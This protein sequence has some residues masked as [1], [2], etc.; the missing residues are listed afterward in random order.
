[1]GDMGCTDNCRLANSTASAKTIIDGGTGV[2]MTETDDNSAV[3]ESWAVNGTSQIVTVDEVAADKSVVF[4]Y[5]GD[6]AD[7][8]ITYNDASIS[9]DAGSGDWIAG[10]TAYVTV[11][12]PDMNKQ[13]G[14]AETLEIG[15]EDA[16]I[17]TIKVGSP[18]T[19]KEADGNSNL[20]SGDANNNAGVQVGTSTL[21]YYTLAVYNT[22]DNS[23]RL[24]IIHSADADSDACGNATCI[25]G[26]RAATAATTSASSTHTWINVTTAH[27]RAELVDLAG[28]AVLNYDVSGPAGDLSSTAVAVYVVDSGE[29]STNNAGGLIDAL[30]AGNARAGVV[31]LDDDTQWIK[32]SDVASVQSFTTTGATEAGTVNVGV[33]FKIT[34]PVGSFLNTTHDYAIA[35]DFCNFDQDNGSNT[36][37]CIYRIEAE[38][39]GD[40]TGVFEGT[41]DYVMLNNSTDISGETESAHAGNDEEVEDLMTTNSDGVT[42]VVMNGVSGTDAIRVVY[43]DTDA[44]QVGTKIGAQLASV[45]H[46]GTADLDADTYEA[47]DMATIT[48][49]DADLNQDSDVRDTYGN[50]SRTFQMNVTG[51]SGVSHMSFE[52]EPITIIETTNDSGIFMGTFK[53]PDFKGQDLS[54]TYY[55]SKDHSG[56]AVEVTDGS[57]V[58]SNSGTV[59]FD[60]SVYPV[61]FSGSSGCTSCATDASDLRK[62]DG[63]TTGQT[64]AGNVT[65]TITVED[66]DFTDDT[67]TTGGASEPGTIVVTLIEGSTTN[68]CFTAGSATTGTAHTSTST[69]QEL[70]PLS[71]TEMGLS[72]YEIE[73]TVDEVQHCG[74]MQTITS[75]DVFQVKYVDTADDGGVTATVYDSSTFDLR[76]G[77]LSVDKDVPFMLHEGRTVLTA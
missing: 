46:S 8:I 25:G 72:V 33:A 43:N 16:I 76:T 48:I 63:S 75:G 64:E 17:P 41:V 22:T 65:M 26:D 29:N 12:D 13:P 1:M 49:V 39:T 9:M 23:E 28:T 6:S 55:D 40:N 73:F 4:T 54:L 45:T 36:H 34:H 71:E 69:V 52:T 70:G 59:S 66:S 50:S 38:E 15:D 56:E 62:G 57:T 51:S 68:T 5:G 3:F 35:A 19:L 37:N 11:T 31:D 21:A 47:A 10:E 60:K 67:L 44:L 74:T 2:I 61:P 24:R 14:Q 58:V 27:T 18:L 32:N 77:S 20:D 7:I 42:V 30:T 53:V